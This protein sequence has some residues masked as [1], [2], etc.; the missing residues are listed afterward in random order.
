MDELVE[1]LSTGTHPVTVGGQNPSLDEFERQIEERGYV[2]IKFTDTAG[3][4]ELGVRVDKAATNLDDANF[5][6]AEG[7]AHVEGVLTLNFV[8]VRCIADI[9]LATLKG[10]GH[11]E[12]LEQGA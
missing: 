2:H 11:L 5:D 3:G 7:N 6:T 9:D 12:I 10:T 8:P 4:T 1:R